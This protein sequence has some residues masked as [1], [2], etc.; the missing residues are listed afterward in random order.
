MA[1]N[2][3]RLMDNIEK[4]GEIGMSPEGG[5]IRVAFT[6]VY[7]K[8][9]DFVIGLMEKAGLKVR[10]DGIGNLYGRLDGRMEGPVLMAGSHIDSVPQ[11]GKYD[12]VLGVLG[13]VECLQSMV[14]QGIVPHYPIEAVAFNAEEGGPLGGTFGS[15]AALGELDVTNPIIVGGL[16]E[17][18][19]TPEGI[20]T[21]AIDPKVGRG[22][23]EL[24]IEQGGVLDAEGIPLGIVTGIV[25][26]RR[27]RITVAGAANH[28]GTTPMRMRKDAL[29]DASRIVT[30][31]WDYA[32]AQGEGF[33]ATVGDM[34]VSPGAINV[35]AGKVSFPVEARSL[36]ENRL[37][38]F[39]K[40]LISLTE[41]ENIRLD[42]H[43]RTPGA[44]MDAD[45]Q[46]I[47]EQSAQKLGFAY[48]FMP[49]GAGHDAATM[50]RHMPAA[51]I[52]VPSRGGISHSPFEFTEAEDIDKGVNLLYEAL[53]AVR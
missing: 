40:K 5:Q 45:L 30:A 25:Q 22:Y 51:M 29:V 26:I 53:L 24:H 21:A 33:V 2:L 31:V 20:R 43:V 49:S 4:L 17:Q 15:K 27:Y 41:A 38:A 34:E 6:P 13:A 9:E 32:Q 47:L 42:F 46:R 7:Q 50:G 36:D 19:M 28:A 18:G 16:H 10:K 11:G 14:E 48:R 12:G 39:E 8:S 3:K 23:F 37:D 35:I 44:A 1:I 52:F